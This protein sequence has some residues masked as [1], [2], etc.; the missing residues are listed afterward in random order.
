ME[1]EEIIRRLDDSMQQN[2]YVTIHLKSN[3][4]LFSKVKKIGDDK[5][6]LSEITGGQLVI[7]G[8]IIQH[9]QNIEI[10]VDD[11]REIK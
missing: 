1:K 6:K 11:I 2:D 7:P 10:C 9:I 3:D 8:K 4:K 5:I